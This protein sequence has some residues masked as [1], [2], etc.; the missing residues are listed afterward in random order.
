M[1][2]RLERRGATA[3]VTLDSP[4]TRNAFTPA[5]KDGLAAAVAEIGADRT[6]RALVLT[7]AGG[8]FCAGGDVR[9]MAA[10]D[11][12]GGEGRVRMQ[13]VNRWMRELIL[14]DRPVI[15]AVDGAAYGG[16]F[17]V[18]LAADFILA[19][20]RARFCMPFLKLGLVPD[21]GASYTLPR[22]LGAQ[23]ARELML[24]AR[25]LPAAEGLQLGLVLELQ[26]PD[27]LLPR[28]LALADSFADAS[29]LAV[30][31]LKRN[32]ADAGALD[33]ALDAEADA[34][35]LAFATTEHR[36]AVR[37]FLDKQAP[38]FQWPQRKP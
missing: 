14:L 6:V 20:P 19:T 7:G 26:E 12:A 24:S 22:A 2:V 28:A 13:A 15:A 3:V 5:L 10:S 23:R 35:A 17:S 38:A 29:A 36:E 32:I 37:R 21:C 25:E 18:A 27:Q 11:L 30:S 34:Q 9:G 8:H 4:S 31:L 16:G 33:R 1:S